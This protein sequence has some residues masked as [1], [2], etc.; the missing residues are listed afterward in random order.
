[1]SNSTN[2]TLVGNS[3]VVRMLGMG[4]VSGLNKLRVRDKTFPE[5]IK[6]SASRGARVRFDVAEVEAWISAKKL[7]RGSTRRDA[8]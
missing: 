8:A 1:M 5:P 3:E 4:S 6:T 7:E 2:T